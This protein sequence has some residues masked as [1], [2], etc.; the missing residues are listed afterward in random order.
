MTGGSGHSAQVSLQFFQKEVFW[1]S[2]PGTVVGPAQTVD[3]NTPRTPQHR[4]P[5]NSAQ[6]NIWEIGI[7]NLIVFL[8]QIITPKVHYITSKR[9]IMSKAL[10]LRSGNKSYSVSTSINYKQITDTNSMLT[11]II[12]LI[13]IHVWLW[14]KTEIRFFWLLTQQTIHMKTA[15]T[16]KQHVLVIITFD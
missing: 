14:Y 12:I 3:W 6:W 5:Y 9:W 8:D 11:I 4:T 16:A 15:C 1:C 2:C 13:I 7:N 10:V